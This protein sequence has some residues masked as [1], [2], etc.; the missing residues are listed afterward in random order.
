MSDVTFGVK[1]TEEMKQELSE[2]MKN[3][4]LS[5][6]EFM[7]M[8]L[9]SYKLEKSRVESSLFESDMKELQVLLNRVQRI[10]L[11]MTEKSEIAY[12]EKLQGFERALSEQEEEY[13]VLGT[14][15]ETLQ[16]VLKEQEDKSKKDEKQIKELKEELKKYQAEAADNKNQLKNNLLL[17]TKFEEEVSYLKEQIEALKRLELE[18]EERNTE[19]TKLKNRNDELASELWFLQREVEKLNLEKEQLTIKWAE[20]KEQMKTTH[21]LE[22]KNQLLEQKLNLN[23]RISELREDNIKLERMF[24]ERLKNIYE[25]SESNLEKK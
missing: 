21:A 14:E 9:T 25:L 17:H 11:N 2:L 10:Y 3:S 23:Q 20:E 18:I 24:N 13:K 7:S 6:K 19:N 1:V 16:Q 4:T 8:L 12:T 5:G 15:Y 22:I